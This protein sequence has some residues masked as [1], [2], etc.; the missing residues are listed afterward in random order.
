MTNGVGRVCLTMV[1]PTYNE[2]DRLGAL[3]ERILAVCESHA[4]SVRV[5]VVDDHSA[6]GTGQLADDW[7]RRAPV[8][9]I[10]RAAKLG[11]GSAVLAGFAAADADVVGVMDADLSHPPE[12]IPVLY[13][14]L[15]SSDLDM[16]VAS[17]YASH[18]GTEAWPTA[19]FLLSR[20][21]CW[22]SQRLTP[23]RDPMSGFFLL[24]RD[25]VRNFET[26]ATGFKIG[27]EL[28]VRAHPRRVAEIGYVFV[29]R[30]AGRSKMTLSEGLMFLRQLLRLHLYSLSTA[31]PAPPELVEAQP[32]L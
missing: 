24:R 31:H 27:L 19:R 3:L 26:P 16:V 4:L 28:L 15:R 6:D 8:R 14:A 20:F 10:H 21:A 17:R 25:C 23:V 29:G 5:I 32:A 2:R 30:K 18:G 11:L 1:V 22:L 7:A 12:L 9:V 13:A